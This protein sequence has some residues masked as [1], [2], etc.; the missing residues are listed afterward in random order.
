MKTAQDP[1][2][3]TDPDYRRLARTAAPLL[4][5]PATTEM[6]A[7]L[8]TL[9][10]A[11][12]VGEALRAENEQLRARIADLDAIAIERR[13]QIE[14]EGWIPEHDD[15]EHDLGEL[16]S[17]AMCYACPP[18]VDLRD[19]VD[20]DGKPCAPSAWPWDDSWWKPSPD[21]RDRELV[22]AGA[23]LEAERDR[24]RRQRVS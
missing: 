24:L 9:E 22:K 21:N 2:R 3:Y 12:D 16:A 18:E 14:E 13:R 20:A 7:V 5:E 6:V 19:C 8:G 23:L 11:L 15:A 17:A 4:G 1:D 10:T